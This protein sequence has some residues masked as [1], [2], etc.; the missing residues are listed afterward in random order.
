MLNIK[1][2]KNMSFLFVLVVF[3]GC[4]TLSSQTT[5]SSSNPEKTT[6]YQ[7]NEVRLKREICRDHID[8][9]KA[10]EESNDI[11]YDQFLYKADSFSNKIEVILEPLYEGYRLGDPDEFP[12]A[13][14][15]KIYDSLRVFENFTRLSFCPAESSQIFFSLTPTEVQEAVV[16]RYSRVWLLSI[17]QQHV[18]RMLAENLKCKR[19]K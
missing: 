10:Q 12:Q 8:N 11:D 14:V 1:W 5:F 6:E 19:N 9:L 17:M 13:L 18:Y 16:S 2:T 3:V 7:R 15:E 4:S